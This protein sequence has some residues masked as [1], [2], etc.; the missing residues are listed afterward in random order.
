MTSTT[1]SA[2]VVL[3]CATVSMLVQAGTAQCA[4][5]DTSFVAAVQDEGTRSFD[6][7]KLACQDAATK[8]IYF[9]D[10]P[11]DVS[12]MPASVAALDSSWVLVW[13]VIRQPCCCS[14][15]LPVLNASVIPR[16]LLHES[17]LTIRAWLTQ[18]PA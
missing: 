14:P 15:R 6:F 4:D 17:A 18:K 3:G 11:E 12:V 8:D 16:A 2:T 1:L 5:G 10:A 9:I 7:S 13:C